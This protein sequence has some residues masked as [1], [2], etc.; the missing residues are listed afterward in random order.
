MSRRGVD[1]ARDQSVG[2]LVRPEDWFE[3]SGGA[4]CLDFANTVS[5]RPTSE[6]IERLETYA[7]LLD[8][9]RR[10]GVLTPAAIRLR[11]SAA[12]AHPRRAARQL[13]DARTCRELLY[14]LFAG[15]AA[16]RDNPAAYAAFN[17]RLQRLLPKTI[18][19]T[20]AA[21][22][23]GGAMEWAYD[24]PPAG[25]GG[26]GDLDEVL[27]PIWWSAAELLT[28]PRLAQLRQCEARDCGW[29]FLDESR[30]HRRRWCDMR[31]CGNREKLR[32]FR[33][34]TPSTAR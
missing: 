33:A 26:L 21:R 27:W 16:S 11:A 19:R 12:H 23:D 13:S 5:E 4:L 8:W 22:D 28:S 3:F 25:A 30:G 34:G 10:A 6:P 1:A 15:R 9:I 7:D 2:R 31:I 14:D 17:A 32:R 18:L 29:L 20:S 24:A